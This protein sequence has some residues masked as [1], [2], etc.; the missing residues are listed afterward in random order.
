MPGLE[1]KLLDLLPE[2]EVGVIRLDIASA[3]RHD[4]IVLNRWLSH[5]VDYSD[6]S[7]SNEK[8]TSH[9]PCPHSHVKCKAVHDAVD[10]L[11]K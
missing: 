2:A 8:G 6:G 1:R 7:A 9:K 5:G 11:T 4:P 10:S 3:V